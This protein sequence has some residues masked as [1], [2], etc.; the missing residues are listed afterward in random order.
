MRCLLKVCCLIGGLFEK[1]GDW[2]CLIMVE[3]RGK[4][5]ER[6]SCDY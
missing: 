2:L 5:M 6:K 4:G 1:V 3:F